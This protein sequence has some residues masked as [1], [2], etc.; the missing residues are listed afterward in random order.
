MW[1]RRRPEQDP[2]AFGRERPEGDLPP[3][4]RLRRVGPGEWVA[5]PTRWYLWATILTLAAFAVGGVAG[6]FAARAYYHKTAT[7]LLLTINGTP[8]RQDDLRNRLEQRYGLEEISRF[9]VYELSRQ[10]AEA[11]RCWPTDEQI[12]KRMEVERAKPDYLERLAVWGMSEE[13]F[14]EELTLDMAQTNLLIRGIEVTPEEVRA[15][16][17]RNADPKNPTARYYIPDEIQVTAVAT[18]TEEAARQA[19]RELAMGVPWNVVATRYS[20]D[21]SRR[22]GGRMPPFSRGGSLF[23]T[24]PATEAAVFAM[25][26]GDRLG[27]VQAARMW[28][29]LRCDN[30]WRRRTIPWNEAKEDARIGAM[31]VK[32]IAQ[33]RQKLEQERQEFVRRSTITVLDPAY[34]VAQDAVL[35]RPIR[36]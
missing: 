21:P 19:L 32:G 31:L 18:S 28:W 15:F 27:P 16:Y 7:V 13:V 20:E 8:F 24:N 14:K 3:G 25:R 30:V 9:A 12:N 26:P 23:A 6:A 17:Q 22:A 5:E 36:W 1:L 35:S 2:F 29:V 33:N 34:G 11:K 10:F 4:F